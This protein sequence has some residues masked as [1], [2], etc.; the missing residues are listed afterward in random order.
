MDTFEHEGL[1]FDVSEAGPPDGAVV[2]ALHGFPQDR[3]SWDPLARELSAAGRRV[4]APDQRGY[5]PLARPAGRAPYRRSRLVSDILAL[6]D[7][8]GATTF[9]LIGHD[10]GGMVAWD[11]ASRHPRRVRTLTV[12]STPHPAAFRDALVRGRQLLHSWYMA[13]LQIPWLPEAT[14]RAAGPGRVGAALHRDGLSHEAASRYAARICSPSSARG[15]IGWY[16]AMP[17]DWRRAVPAVDVPTLYAW[18]ARDPYL[19]R[20]AA[21]ATARYVTA[22]FRFEVLEA[23]GHWLPEND[24]V[25]LGPVVLRHLLRE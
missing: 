10:W 15:P 23:A 2:I 17:L 21:D 22:A 5:S 19:T 18:G 20:A 6:A 9:D 12:F 11:L 8:A 7:T 4:L 3:R 1:T 14:A 16:R 25:R 24:A 13:A